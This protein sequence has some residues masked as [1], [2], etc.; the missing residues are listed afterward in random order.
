MNEGGK[1]VATGTLK[2]YMA[3]QGTGF[4]ISRPLFI[5]FALFPSSYYLDSGPYFGRSVVFL[6]FLLA[7]GSSG[8]VVS[9]SVC[10]GRRRIKA[11]ENKIRSPDVSNLEPFPL[12]AF[13]FMPWACIYW[14]F[15]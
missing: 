5:T 10:F 14:C 15:A 7:F 8:Q 9:G 12:F 3:D 1:E 11:I 13:R 2:H 4:A 6:L